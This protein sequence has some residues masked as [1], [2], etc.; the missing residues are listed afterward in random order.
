MQYTNKEKFF[1]SCRAAENKN[2]LFR[3]V[4][5][6]ASQ[7]QHFRNK[8]SVKRETKYKHESN[9]W[10]SQEDSDWLNW[11]IMVEQPISREE[12]QCFAP[13]EVEEDVK[14]GAEKEG[15]FLFQHTSNVFQRLAVRS[16]ALL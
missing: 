13:K 6:E 1:T 7:S 10:G 9:R 14:E 5:G 11:E 16:G 2:I 4:G 3:P 15:V 8:T 12:G